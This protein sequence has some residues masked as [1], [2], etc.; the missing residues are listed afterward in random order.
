MRDGVSPPPRS[1]AAWGWAPPGWLPPWAAAMR[2]GLPLALLGLLWFLPWDEGL[3]APLADWPVKTAALLGAAAPA[4]WFGLAYA[5]AVRL[6]KRAALRATFLWA[7]AFVWLGVTQAWRLLP[8][9]GPDL[10]VAWVTAW[11]AAMAVQTW[12]F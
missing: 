5:R 2:A 6:T 11:V 3:A 12:R 7:A 9:P 8:E 4:V 1:E 10:A